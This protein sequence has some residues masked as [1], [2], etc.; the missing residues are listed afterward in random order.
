[1]Y[2]LCIS[3]S[4]SHASPRRS[5]GLPCPQ[6]QLPFGQLVLCVQ[7]PLLLWRLLP[8][9]S[10]R[11][12]RCSKATCFLI[13]SISFRPRAM[14]AAHCATLLLTPFLRSSACRGAGFLTLP[15]HRPYAPR[16]QKKAFLHALS[17]TLFLF[18]AVLGGVNVTG[19]TTLKKKIK[20]VSKGKSQ[21][22]KKASSS[23]SGFQKNLHPHPVIARRYDVA[24]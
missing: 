20:K 1:M 11:P 8:V 10:V 21:V 17:S 23:P 19:S 24:N 2:C 16:S 18:T 7:R 12:V 6:Y 14:L 3:P 15:Q 13:C 22:Y 5:S 9:R 4:A